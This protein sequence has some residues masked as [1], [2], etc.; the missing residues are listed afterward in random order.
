M[1]IIDSNQNLED[2]L[3]IQCT[4]IKTKNEPIKLQQVVERKTNK[5][6][7]NSPLYTALISLSSCFL[8]FI[9]FILAY[10]AYQHKNI[11]NKEILNLVKNI[12]EKNKVQIFFL[13]RNLSLYKCCNKALRKVKYYL[14]LY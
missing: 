14:R 9:I 12:D 1:C 11:K 7:E 2:V 4:V 13:H 3:A 5:K 10:C 6:K 8:L